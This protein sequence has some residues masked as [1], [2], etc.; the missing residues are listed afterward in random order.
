MTDKGLP[1]IS[2]NRLEIQAEYNIDAPP[3]RVWRALTEELQ[4]WWG[5]PYKCCDDTVEILLE[6]R[7]GGALLEKGADGTEVVWGI[8]SGFT[9]DSYLELEGSCGM[10]WPSFGNWSHMLSDNGRGGTTLKFRHTA[11]GLFKPEQQKNYGAGWD[12]LLGTRLKSWC[13]DGT[14][15][16]LGNEPQWARQNA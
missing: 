3:D 5:A 11:L 13:E 1:E 2:L 9:P 14:R 10:A 12:D 6:L 16:G 8:V 4:A 15:L 7:G